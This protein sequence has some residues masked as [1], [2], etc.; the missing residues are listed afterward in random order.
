[1]AEGKGRGEIGEKK[2]NVAAVVAGAI[3]TA[4]TNVFARTRGIRGRI[5]REDF[6]VTVAGN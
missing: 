4:G 3:K 5:W 1:M 6:P 2:G